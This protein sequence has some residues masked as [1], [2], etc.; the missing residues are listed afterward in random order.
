MA[1][2]AS[3]PY[4]A[5]VANEWN[6]IRAGYFTE[7]RRDAAIAKANLPPGAIVADVGTGTGFV[8]LGLASQAAKVIGFD[9]SAEMLAVARRNLST[10]ANVDFCEAAGD[11]RLVPDGTFDGVFANR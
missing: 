7:H 8:A 6:D 10:L 1:Q 11:Q 5:A 3:N 2:S 9:A 4:F